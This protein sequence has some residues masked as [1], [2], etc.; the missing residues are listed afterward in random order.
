VIGDVAGHNIASASTMGQVRSLL[1]AYAIDG[2]DPGRALQRTNAAVARLLPDAL[3]GVVY[4]VLDPATGGFRRA[5]ACSAIPTDSSK[6]GSAT[7]ARASRR[8]AETLRVLD[9]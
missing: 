3:A 2:P 1:R 5:R 7:S 9:D 6:S 8:F 4:A